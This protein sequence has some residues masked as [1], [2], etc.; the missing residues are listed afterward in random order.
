MLRIL[1]YFLLP[2]CVLVLFSG[3]GD[4]PADRLY[5]LRL[6]AAPTDADWQKA[7]PRLVSV[8]GGRPHQLRSFTEIDEDTV[9]TSTASC[10]H[11]SRLP[12]PV[13]VDMRAF[14]TDDDLY[15]RLSWEDA[16]RDQQMRDWLF[17]GERWINTGAM[18]DGFGLLWDA[19]GAFPR[20]SC[21][22]ACHISDFGVNRSSFHATNRMQLADETGW[23]DLWN[24]KAGRTAPFGFADD[25]YLDHRGMQG[26]TDGE[27]F[28]EN[29]RAS[30]AGDPHLKP[31]SDGDQPI[32]DAERR[33][34]GEGYRPPGTLAPGYLVERPRG[35]RADLV[36]LSRHQGGRWVVVLKRALATGDPR[37]VVF[38]PGDQVGVAFGLALMDHTLYEHYASQS[39]ERLVLLPA[40]PDVRGEENS[41]NINPLSGMISSA[42]FKE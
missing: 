40:E 22:Y 38:V 15:L 12:E 17:D 31:F 28:R 26:D 27:L 11:G 32:Y 19:R 1:F 37:D 8:R 21:S 10:H 36:A 30:L 6:D 3:C 2:L 23:L 41:S 9:H 16:T 7:L 18:E 39:T 33:P 14:Y 13:S 29:S 35:G 24:W 4:I 34:A 5:A 20:F 42:F 25:R